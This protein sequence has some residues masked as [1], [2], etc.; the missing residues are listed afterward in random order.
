MR[1]L[2]GG[3]D[4]AGPA[5][6]PVDT[7]VGGGRVAAGGG[8]VADGEFEVALLG[9]FARRRE[10]ADAAD[11]PDVTDEVVDVDETAGEPFSF[12]DEAEENELFVVDIDG[13]DLDGIPL[14]IADEGRTLAAGAGQVHP[15]HVEVVVGARWCEHH[16]ERR[17]GETCI[18]DTGRVA[19]APDVALL[20]EDVVAIG[21]AVQPVWMWAVLATAVEAVATGAARLGSVD[22]LCGVQ[23]RPGRIVIRR[24]GIVHRRSGVLLRTDVGRGRVALVDTRAGVGRNRAVASRLTVTTR[25]VSGVGRVAIASV[26]GSGLGAVGRGI[27]RSP[28]GDRSSLQSR[29][30]LAISGLLACRMPGVVFTHT[31]LTAEH[32]R[33][34][35]R[36]HSDV[37]HILPSGEWGRL[38]RPLVGLDW[39]FAKEKRKFVYLLSLKKGQQGTVGLFLNFVNNKTP[40]FNRGVSVAFLLCLTF[41][42]WHWFGWHRC[43]LF[44][45]RSLFL[46]IEMVV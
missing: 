2:A 18:V 44:W 32:G 25:G 10:V 8:G 37:S 42:G 34:R 1:L 43:W 16:L 36:H 26:T 35:E 28:V 7:V 5:L 38:R 12:G 31:L 20:G 45:S 27:G 41:V 40:R 14:A 33:E 11:D 3:R 39:L 13:I 19:L 17:A 9:Q 6:G 24:G 15:R 21:A 30:R 46:S 23:W 22:R 29:Q 4:A